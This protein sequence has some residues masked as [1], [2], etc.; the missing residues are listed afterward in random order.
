MEKSDILE[1]LYARRTFGIK[2]GLATQR[3]LLDMLG[4]PQ[5]SFA[6]VHVAGTNGKGSV[7]AMLDSMIRS[8]GIRCGRYTSPHLVD[9]NERFVIDG[10]PISDDE[11][12]E[13]TA[14]V[15]SA[16]ARVEA[17]GVQTPTFFECSTAIAFCAFSR[18]G[19]SLAVIET[20]LGGR[21]DA[22]NVVTPLLSVITRIGLDHC[23]WLGDSLE[24]IAAEKGG[25]IKSGRS[26]VRGAMP[27]DAARVIDSIAMDLGCRVVDAAQSVSLTVRGGK[28][29]VAVSGS[30]QDYGIVHPSLA[31]AYQN[32]N[33][34]TA[35][36]AFEE[37][38]TLL[39]VTWPE[40]AVKKGLANVSWSGRFQVIESEPP[41]LLDG[42]HNADGARALRASIKSS[43]GKRKVGVV[44]GM[45]AEKD[46]SAFISELGGFVKHVWCVDIANPRNMGADLCAQHAKRA[47]LQAE[48]IGSPKI[49][50]DAAKE[51]AS[52]CEGVIVVCGSLF[53]V[54]EFLS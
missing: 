26:V 29:G 7:C 16:A 51:W 44:L 40:G 11:L 22:T 43:F 45:C 14:E 1:R 50:M 49:A 23:E 52:D 27:D 12:L 5:E 42:A 4:N 20:G 35:V 39:G 15:E 28:G 25:I 38:G 41:V 17:S 18:R 34:A 19:V 47:G 46:V 53:L 30:E 48:S 2:P 13:I 37:L 9:F 33:M 24:E 31:G 3:A 8:A 36:A 21:L 54:G 10:G 32:E 6:S